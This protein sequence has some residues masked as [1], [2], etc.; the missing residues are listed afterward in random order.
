MEDTKIV[1]G[2]IRAVK[3]NINDKEVLV[4]IFIG[5]YKY[6]EGFVKKDTINELVSELLGVSE[7]EEDDVDFETFSIP[8]DVYDIKFLGTM[9]DRYFDLFKDRR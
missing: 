7:E 8:K 2:P 9:P 6:T 3:V 5:D 1:R 4:T